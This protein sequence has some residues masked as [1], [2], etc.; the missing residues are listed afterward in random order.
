[1]ATVFSG[2]AL[3]SVAMIFFSLTSKP[4]A[5]I[6][7][8]LASKHV[9]WVFRFGPQNRQLLFGDLGHQNHCN[10]FLACVLKLSRRWFVG[11]ALKPTGGTRWHGH[12]SK[13]KDLLHVDA[14]S[15]RIF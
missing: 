10:D 2:L 5:T 15:V 13:F 12:A 1:M 8:V 11:C 7:P 4:V 14:S 6:S 9:A 3:K